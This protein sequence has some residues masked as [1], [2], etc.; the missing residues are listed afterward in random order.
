MRSCR[1]CGCDDDHACPGGCF[2]VLA[3]VCSQCAGRLSPAD[4]APDL[5]NAADDLVNTGYE[6]VMLGDYVPELEPELPP[7]SNVL[8]GL[9]MP[10]P[11]LIWFGE[12]REDV[13]GIH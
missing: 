7:A 11:P 4:A 6:Q 1:Y 5:L 3:D 10:L 2:W 12:E 8:P 9:L 13:D